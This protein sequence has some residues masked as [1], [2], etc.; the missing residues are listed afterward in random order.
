[1]DPRVMSSYL[2]GLFSPLGSVVATGAGQLFKF[3][4]HDK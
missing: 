1:M 3:L 2:G 4:V